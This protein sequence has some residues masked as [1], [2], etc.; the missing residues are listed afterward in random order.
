MRI[1][2]RQGEQSQRHSRLP[3]QGSSSESALAEELCPMSLSN[4]LIK[5]GLGKL[6]DRR[7]AGNPR[8]QAANRNRHQVRTR[9]MAAQR[10]ERLPCKHEVWSSNP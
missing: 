3:M 5:E 4:C 9:E 7:G 8:E 2:H 1:H 10:T 6:R